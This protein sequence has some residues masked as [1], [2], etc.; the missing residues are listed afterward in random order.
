[1]ARRGLVAV[2]A[3]DIGGYMRLMEAHTDGTMAAPK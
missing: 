2:Q 3:A 1:M